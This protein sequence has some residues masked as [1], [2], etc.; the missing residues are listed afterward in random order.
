M[1]L[2]ARGAPR[3]IALGYIK[4]LKTSAFVLTGAFAIAVVGVLI[5]TPLWYLA[6]EHTRAYTIAFIGV[7][8][9]AGLGLAVYRLATDRGS[10]KRLLRRIARTSGFLIAL[11]LLYLTVFLYTRAVFA[12]AVPLTVVLVAA[13]GL[14]LHGKNDKQA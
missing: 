12:A 7:V 11:F 5:V 2:Y 3:G 13:V 1:R 8:A 6:T 14:L 4:I 9:T 10:R